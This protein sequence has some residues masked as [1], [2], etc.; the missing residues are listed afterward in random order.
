MGGTAVQTRQLCKRGSYA[1]LNSG[2]LHVSGDALAG[3]GTLYVKSPCKA[4]GK[5]AFGAQA[6]KREG[7]ERCSLFQGLGFSGPRQESWARGTHLQRQSSQA[8]QTKCFRGREL[9]VDV[10]GGHTRAAPR[11]RA[12]AWGSRCAHVVSGSRTGPTHG[13]GDEKVGLSEMGN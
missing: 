13:A 9:C 7:V 12:P 2:Y 3:S 5:R 6:S 10:P 11:A 1:N 4:E 8:W